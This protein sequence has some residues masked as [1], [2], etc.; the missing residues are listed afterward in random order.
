MK[1]PHG[2]AVAREVHDGSE[3]CARLRLQRERQQ[4]ALTAIAADTK[5][6]LSLLKRWSVMTFRIGRKAFFVV[7]V[8][9]PRPSHRSRT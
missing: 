1:L 6:Q 9:A 3:L 2:H 4:V 7:P 5:I 8:F